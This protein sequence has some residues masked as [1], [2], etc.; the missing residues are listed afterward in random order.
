MVIPYKITDDKKTIYIL[1]GYI[2]Y[3]SEIQKEIIE[4]QIK[5]LNYKSHIDIG[6]NFDFHNNPIEEIIYMSPPSTSDNDKFQK[7]NLNN[8]P[9]KLRILKLNLTNVECYKLDNLPS[10]LKELY[11]STLI[12][13]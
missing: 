9:E 1:Q 2:E 4:N 10:G 8:L 13:L 11:L 7:Q 3:L 5:I 12:L 6:T